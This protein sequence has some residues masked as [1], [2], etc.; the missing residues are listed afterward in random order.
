MFILK[1]LRR[2][3]TRIDP[4]L[5]VFSSFHGKFADS[6]K[7]LTEPIHRKAPEKTIVWLLNDVNN[8]EVP[9]YVVK[10][11]YGSKEADRYYGKAK[12]IIDNVYCD[13]EYY[14]QGTGLGAKLKFKFGTYL[15]NKRGQKYYTSWH[16][17]MIKKI[18]SDSVRNK[19]YN[20]S[21]ANTTM[22]LDNKFGL[23]VMRRITQ[24]T[25]KMKLMGEPRDD[26]LF[27]NDIDKKALKKKLGILINKKAIIYAPTFRSNDDE[28]KNIRNS[29][30]RQL[31]ELDINKM[32]DILSEKFGGDWVFI[33]RF[34]YHVEKAIDW[35]ELNKKYR[36]KLINGNKSE[37]IVDY[38][39]CSDALISDAS[40]SIYEASLANKPTFAFF[41]DYHH[42]ADDER[43]F[44][45][46]IDELPWQTSLDA[47]GLYADI[48]NY[49]Q[50]EYEK[51]FSEFR[52]KL[53][54]TPRE[55]C[56]DKIAEY[57]L[58]D[59]EK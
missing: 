20:F 36:G 34:H 18:G 56:A 39:A 37:D 10:V 24:N 48:R 7:V 57:I 21:C 59:L 23:D 11:K 33:A 1:L 30:I 50:K 55:P 46:S 40:S 26:V 15:K 51:K 9:D 41:P 2:K 58:K 8:E 4:N 29:G 12:A 5:L 16:G 35:A 31:E 22:F 25:I 42:F 32:L 19:S 54:F 14:T 27:S 28:T 38:I 47:E 45:F 3:F 13:H 53:G 49:D 17:A 43:G 52:E 6:P 44:Y